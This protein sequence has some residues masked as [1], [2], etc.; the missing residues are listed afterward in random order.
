MKSLIRSW[1]RG[2]K[3]IWKWFPIVWRDRDFD[4]YY[5]EQVLYFKLKNTYNFF[6]S[7][8][9]VTNW[10][11]EN[12]KKSLKALRICITILDR[13]LNDF[14]IMNFV[15][16]ESFEETKKI[17]AIEERDERVLGALLGKYLSYWWD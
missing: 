4:N 10:E 13:R 12:Q 3:N 9:S 2:I 15:P 1:Y 6:I 11:I 17:Y 16:T 14:Y 5:I 7:K 8:N